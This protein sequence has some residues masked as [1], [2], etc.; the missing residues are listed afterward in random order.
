MKVVGKNHHRCY[1][2]RRRRCCLHLLFLMLHRSSIAFLAAHTT[3]IL[4][5]HKKQKTDQI[6]VI[7]I[8]IMLLK[9][10]NLENLAKNLESYCSRFK[11]LFSQVVFPQ[12][13]NKILPRIIIRTKQI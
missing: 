9:K 4:N 12:Y 6:N 11:L 3:T 13:L 5:Q 1:C 2:H 10:K 8:M 7:M